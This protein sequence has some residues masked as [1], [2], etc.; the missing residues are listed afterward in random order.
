MNKSM[1][2]NEIN[3]IIFPSLLVISQLD[4][5]SICLLQRLNRH[6]QQKA[7]F[8]MLRFLRDGHGAIAN[9]R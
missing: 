5:L 3:L 2:C 4:D 6:E 9:A 7:R 1:S 8:A